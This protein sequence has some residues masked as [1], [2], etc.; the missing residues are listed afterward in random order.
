MLDP[1]AAVVQQSLW[2]G[3]GRHSLLWT[4]AQ[5]CAGEQQVAPLLTASQHAPV[6]LSLEATT[7]LRN[8]LF[9]THQLHQQHCGLL[10]SL[11][12]H[13]SKRGSHHHPAAALPLPSA[14]D[15]PAAQA[16]CLSQQGV[17]NGQHLHT[18]AD[19]PVRAHDCATC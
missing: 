13:I 17:Y 3:S 11:L 9:P 5:L 18:I 8:L 10:I 7:H 6:Q 19:M 12:L 16:A 15:L 1:S 4:V 2:T 14:D